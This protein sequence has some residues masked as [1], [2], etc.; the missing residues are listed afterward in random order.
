MDATGEQEFH[1]FVVGSWH[2]LLRTAYLLTGDHGEAEDLVQS[3]L[4]KVHR[5]WERIERRD[6]P[7]VFARRV[8]IN[9]NSSIWRRRVRLRE[10][11]TDTLPDPSRRGTD[12][13]QMAAYDLRDQLR[14]ACLTLPPRQR[15]V[16]VLRYFEDMT[17][18]DAARTLGISVGAVKSQTS[19]GLERL[20]AVVQRET[21]D[22]E[23]RDGEA[24]APG[25][26]RTT[27]RNGS[28][29]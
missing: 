16:L 13:D 29:A 12:G 19:R 28:P 17:E 23:T 11:P 3:T 25:G 6:A 26:A 2:S 10:Q 20:R 1:D 8:M 22:G 14:R 27:T 18:A 9:L 21:R 7:G 24:G 5:H 4:V 15:A